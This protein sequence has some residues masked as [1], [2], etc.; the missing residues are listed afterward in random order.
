[1]ILPHSNGPYLRGVPLIIVI[2]LSWLWPTSASP[3]VLRSGYVT[4]AAG[5]TVDPNIHF[6]Q[7]P[8]NSGFNRPLGFTPVDFA[9]ARHGLPARITTVEPQWRFENV[10][11]D[12][13]LNY[14]PW[15][16]WINDTGAYASGGSA[17]YAMDFYVWPSPNDSVT[18]D[19]RFAADDQLGDNSN[20]HVSGVYIGAGGDSSRV[21]PVPGTN[22]IG[23]CCLPV[24]EF[25]FNRDITSYVTPG[26]NTLYLYVHDT[27]GSAGLLFSALVDVWGTVPSFA[28]VARIPFRTGNS[29][30]GPGTQ[31]TLI[32]MLVGPPMSPWPS[33]F[34]ASQFD[35]ARAGPHPLL[36]SG[37]ANGAWIS[38]LNYS[39]TNWDL[40]DS[41]AKWINNTGSSALVDGIAN[42]CLYA[43]DLDLPDGFD[44]ALFV[45]D[46]AT[47]DECGT[48]TVPGIYINELPLPR[49]KGVS[50][51]NAAYSYQANIT[52][53]V[54]PGHNTLYVYNKN[55]AGPSGVIMSGRVVLYARD[56]VDGVTTEISSEPDIRLSVW[57]N[58]START[59]FVVTTS[60][61]QNLTARIVDVAGR[62]VRLLHR[63]T[64]EPGRHE[65]AWDGLDDAGHKVPPGVYLAY[66]ETATSSR[67]TRI[68]RV[69]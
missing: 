57:P 34:T 25:G 1:M 16:R 67:S 31:D 2:V 53:Y 24:R 50:S 26:L 49:T 52:P 54:V 38:S 9:T 62:E 17:L 42:T 66:T 48:S 14:D 33:P 59:M 10:S 30:G 58:P 22:G 3:L 23:L 7:G 44:Y 19:L 20:S 60:L 21:A 4:G 6:L 15:A 29:T 28:P 36:V 55:V 51:F 63:G 45:A 12:S 46:F 8:P 64:L 11:N 32:N 5:Q 41:Q 69:E 39:S 56:L 61:V 65:F 13:L 27:G 40:Y 43:L 18:M 35:S 68:V 37:L 47:D